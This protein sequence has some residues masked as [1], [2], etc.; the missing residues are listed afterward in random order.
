LEVDFFV[1]IPLEAG[2]DFDAGFSL[3]VAA[4]VA[5]AFDLATGFLASPVTAFFAAPFLAVVA[6]L[7]VAFLVVLTVFAVLGAFLVVGTFAAVVF[8]VPVDTDL[9]GIFFG[10]VVVALTFGVPLAG[11]AFFKGALAGVALALVVVVVLV[12]V[13][14]LEAGLAF[15]LAASERA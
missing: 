13:I 7:A 3:E 11:V 5:F 1:A 4:V 9:A 15:S 12:A 10:A 14:L 2:L 8:F 6:F